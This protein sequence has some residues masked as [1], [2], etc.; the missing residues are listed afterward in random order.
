MRSLTCFL[1]GI[2]CAVAGWFGHMHC[3]QEREYHARVREVSD[4][5]LVIEAEQAENRCRIGTLE[6]RCKCDGKPCCPCKKCPCK[7]GDR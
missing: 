1:V 7:G 4:R 2:V 3:Q 6:K 5:V